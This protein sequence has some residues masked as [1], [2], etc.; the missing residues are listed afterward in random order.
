[1]ATF[2]TPPH[3]RDKEEPA[4]RAGRAAPALVGSPGADGRTLETLAP[5]AG[6]PERTEGWRCREGALRDAHRHGGAPRDEKEPAARAGRAAPNQPGTVA[7]R[8]RKRRERLPTRAERTP[9]ENN[10]A[11]APNPDTHEQPSPRTSRTHKQ[12]HPRTSSTHKQPH[13]PPGTMTRTN[14]TSQPASIIR[15]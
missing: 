13:C 14:A 11:A 4:A 7:R 1:V 5:G 10:I 8:Q 12:P 3:P 9:R 2:A 15:R 6:V